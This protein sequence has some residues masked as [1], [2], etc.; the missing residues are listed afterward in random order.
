MKTLILLRHA[1]A[2]SVYDAKNDF[3]RNLTESG[4]EAAKKV[5]ETFSGKPFKPDI[6]LCSTANRTKQ[7]LDIF[8]QNSNFKPEIVMLEDLYMSTAT[9]MFRNINKYDRK[10]TIMVIGHNDGLSFLAD[11]LSSSG[12]AP[13]PTSSLL[14]LSFKK[15][16]D[17]EKGNI[18]LFIYPNSI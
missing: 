8:L 9:D 18:E 17:L 6:I 3:E 11:K 2:E 4:R 12:C 16:I 1:K 14:V 15:S 13:L 5:A 7:T 10:K